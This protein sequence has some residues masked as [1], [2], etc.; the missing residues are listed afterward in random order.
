MQ[1]K[2]P[3]KDGLTEARKEHVDHFI[4]ALEDRDLA[5]QLLL[6]RLKDADALEI[7]LRECEKGRARQRKA[8]MGSN[9]FRQKLFSNANPAPSK[10]ARA[11]RAICV[12]N[13]DSESGSDLS[14][15]DSEQ[16][17]RAIYLANASDR[18][19]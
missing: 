3:V 7:T 19:A 13:E 5:D 2:I 11:V 12:E 8:T 6:L 10:P 16:H 15:S 9:K 18:H 14:K 17:Q 1:A 4:E